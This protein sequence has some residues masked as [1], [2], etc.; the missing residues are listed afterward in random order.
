M[1]NRTT[2]E[3]PFC[4]TCGVALYDRWDYKGQR[5]DHFPDCPRRYERSV[6]EKQPQNDQEEKLKRNHQNLVRFLGFMALSLFSVVGKHYF[7]LIFIIRV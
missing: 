2:V 1:N 4:D 5:K 6:V 7:I 3:N